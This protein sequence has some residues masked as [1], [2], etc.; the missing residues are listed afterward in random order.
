MF[1]TLPRLFTTHVKIQLRLKSMED[2]NNK[3]FRIRLS[4]IRVPRFYTTSTKK[5]L[6]P[7][8][9]QENSWHGIRVQCSHDAYWSSVAPGLT[10]KVGVGATRMAAPAGHSTE[11]TVWPGAHMIATMRGRFV[12]NT[13]TK[14]RMIRNSVKNQFCIKLKKTARRV[15][16]FNEIILI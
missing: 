4:K 1:I 3:N 10:H 5:W 11:V 9:K 8:G 13:K 16:E 15:M 14:T 2:K 6:S 7:Q 12:S